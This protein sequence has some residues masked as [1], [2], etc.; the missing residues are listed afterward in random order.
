MAAKRVWSTVL[1]AIAL[2]AL[3]PSGV[4]RADISVTA[5]GTVVPAGETGV[6]SGNLTCTN[7]APAVVIQKGAALDLGGFTLMVSGPGS[8]DDAIVCE[9]RKCTVES[10]ATGGRIVAS[11]LDSVIDHT[12]SGRGKVVLRDVEIEIS[13]LDPRRL[14]CAPLGPCSSMSDPAAFLGR[15]ATASPDQPP[16]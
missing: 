5:C 4:A 9:D 10:S 6:L 2:A 3:A 16:S 15:G 12:V 14:A 11:G 13:P 7:A 8:G 1:I